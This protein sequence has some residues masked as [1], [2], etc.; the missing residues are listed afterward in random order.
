MTTQTPFL[1]NRKF[2]SHRFSREI[3][4]DISK[5][6]PDNIT[7]GLYIVKD[8]TVIF[9]CAL[10]TVKLSWWL[11]PLAVLLIGSHQRGLTT[12]AHDA[13][14]KILAKNRTL[15]FVYGVLFAAYPIFQKHFA[16]RESHIK[17][18]HPNLGDPN[19]DPDLQF[20]ISSGVYETAHPLRYYFRIAIF[21]ILGG[22]TFNYLK[23]LMANRFKTTDA[24]RENFERRHL[25]IDT[26]GFYGFWIVVLGACYYFKVLDYFLLFWAIPYLTSFQIL[27]WFIELAEHN[28]MCEDSKKD[29]Y[30]T[31][32]RKGPLIEKMLFG[33]NLDEYHLEHH[34]SPSVPFWHLKKAQAIHKRDP[35]YAA[36]SLTWGGLFSSGPN[37]QKSVIKQLLE[38]NRERYLQI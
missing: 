2:T 5:L 37:G 20:F 7:G 15:N 27:G 16:Y 14:H 24:Q 11:Y 18:H 33:V 10:A 31:R 6:R 25:L 30:L 1:F 21:P 29:I 4:K 12:I 17:N 36:L 38:R 8:Y 19:R 22:A 26:T 3:K 9:M 23:Y 35:E 13:A 34:L 28:P 32:N